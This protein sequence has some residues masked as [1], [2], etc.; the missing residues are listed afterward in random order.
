[1]TDADGGAWNT[2]EAPDA[3]TAIACT[4]RQGALTRKFPDTPH[5]RISLFVWLQSGCGAVD[6]DFAFDSIDETDVRGSLRLTEQK[7]EL[8]RKTADFGELEVAVSSIALPTI[9]E[10]FHVI[11]IERQ[12]NDWY[13]F[14]EE[15]FLGSIPIDQIGQ[16]NAIRLVVHG[17][18]PETGE[19]SRAF[20]SDVQLYQLDQTDR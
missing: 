13:V 4:T 10:R 11:H 1:M 9:H 5:P 6:I 16:G 20:F 12:P 17:N 8:G 3:S 2:V 15:K 14:L 19:E 7:S 18:Q